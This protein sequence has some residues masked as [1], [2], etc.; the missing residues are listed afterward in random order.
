MYSLNLG[1]VDDKVSLITIFAR[2]IPVLTPRCIVVSHDV[3]DARSLM[4]HGRR[5]FARARIPQRDAL[6]KYGSAREGSAHKQNAVER[7][8][9][10]SLR[11]MLH[12]PRLVEAS[13]ANE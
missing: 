5:I 13:A 9:M 3:D 7:R 12:I 11:F 6:A 8:Q 1:A 2:A 4:D 10:T